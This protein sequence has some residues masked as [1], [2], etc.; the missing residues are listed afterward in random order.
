MNLWLCLVFTTFRSELKIIILITI[1]NNLV[2]KLPDLADNLQYIAYEMLSC[3]VKLSMEAINCDKSKI[4]FFGFIENSFIANLI[5][6]IIHY[7]PKIE[8]MKPK[9]LTIMLCIG[10]FTFLGQIDAAA[11]TVTDIDGN[12]Y[13]TVTIG[14]QTWLQ[15]NL[16]ALHYADGTEITPTWVYNNSTSNLTVYGRLYDWDAAMHDS[17][18]P[19]AQG[20]CMDGWHV[21]TDTEW[22]TLGNFLGGNNVAGGKMKET[23]TEHWLS[24][25]TGATNS[26][27]FTALP[28]G[29]I[30][31]TIFQFLR[32]ASVIWSSSQSG[33]N[34]AK[35]RVLSHDDE[36]LRPFIW[37]K[38]LGYSIR[39]LKNQTTGINETEY[40][41]KIRVFPNPVQDQFSL[42]ADEQSLIGC[43][44]E[45]YDQYGRLLKQF[46]ITACKTEIDI[47]FLSQGMYFLKIYDGKY[48]DSIKIIK[49]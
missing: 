6:H 29:E 24:P 26:S 1:R 15:E 2:D 10:L 28:A 38:S 41:K 43:K 23:G 22:T 40:E 36:A 8:I 4:F 18:V 32:I 14:T 5:T 9:N 16:K 48:L 42:I 27:G 20:A 17:T 34:N 19:G 21:P 12:V 37:A 25:N 46:D 11:Q 31:G 13:N 39:C 33:T 49:L 30:D 45:L 47:S 3:A 7:E 35:Y 44:L